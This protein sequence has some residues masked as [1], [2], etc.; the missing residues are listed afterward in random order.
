MYKWIIKKKTDIESNVITH[1]ASLVTKVYH[2]KQGIDFYETLS[3]VA[4]LKSIKILLVIVS[5]YDYKIWQR[6][7]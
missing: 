1:K 5:H 6:D 3:P 7:V 2:K 4:I